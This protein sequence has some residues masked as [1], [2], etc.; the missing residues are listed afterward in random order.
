MY[1]RQEHNRF[2]E[3]TNSLHAGADTSLGYHWKEFF[4]PARLK[5]SADHDSS[6][7]STSLC[8]APDLCIR[9]LVNPAR[10]TIRNLNV[11][12]ISS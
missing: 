5:A 7:P 2:G 8:M 11:D 1:K 9:S 3:Y 6:I 4:E 12:S 10:S